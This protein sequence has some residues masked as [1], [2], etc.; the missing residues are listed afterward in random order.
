MKHILV[1]DDNEGIVNSI[2]KVLTHLGF[3][4]KVARDGE[5]GIQLFNRCFNFDCVITDINMPRMNGVEVAQYIR[6]SDKPEIPVIAITGFGEGG[7]DK[8]L[9]SGSLLKP[10]KLRSLVEVVRTQGGGGKS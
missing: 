1:I 10:F 9:F 7:I 8:E 6:N 2:S 4:V 5:E 3:D